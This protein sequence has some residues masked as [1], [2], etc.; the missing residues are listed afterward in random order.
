MEIKNDCVV[1]LENDYSQLK[2][3]DEILLSLSVDLERAEVLAQ[4]LTDTYF[5]IDA[6]DPGEAWKLRA[7]H[8][9]MGIRADMVFDYII[10]MAQNVETAVGIVNDVYA[11][12]KA[13]AAV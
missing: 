2:K 6:S 7:C 5:N 1:G 12:M 13:A 11:K 9:E 8:H 4:D 10:E 3:M